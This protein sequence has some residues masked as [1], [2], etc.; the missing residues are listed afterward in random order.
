MIL[1][2]TNVW[3]E[4]TKPTPSVRVTNWLIDHDAELWLSVIVIAE[5]RRGLEMPKA[6]ARRGGL[7]TW[8]ATLEA[9]Y[10]TRILPFDADM[11]HLFGALLAR[12]NGEATLLD[13]QIAAQALAHDMTLA[14]RNGKDFAWTGVKLVNPWEE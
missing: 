10:A 3:S 8:L 6:H 5:I 7:L 1:V 9:D 14:T 12:R 4:L 13:V 2:D 11:A